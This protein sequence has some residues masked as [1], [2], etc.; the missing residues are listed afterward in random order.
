MVAKF[1]GKTSCG[2]ITGEIY[3]IKIYTRDNFIIIED[4]QSEAICPYSSIKVVNDNWITIKLS[5]SF[6]I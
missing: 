5:K 1:I 6:S 2:F 3:S 4:T